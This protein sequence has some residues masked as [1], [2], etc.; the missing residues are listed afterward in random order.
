MRSVLVILL[1]TFAALWS[2]QA[3][4]EVNRPY[5]AAVTTWFST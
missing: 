4:V 3:P 1:F 5:F 2:C